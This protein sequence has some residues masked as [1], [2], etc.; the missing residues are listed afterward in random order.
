M[1]WISVSL[2]ELFYSNSELN[3]LTFSKFWTYVNIFAIWNLISPFQI[4]LKK[5]THGVVD[6]ATLIDK[7]VYFRQITFQT[8]WLILD[9]FDL[10]F[11]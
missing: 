9:G 3:S 11:N 6:V 7:I 1:D 5:K 4:K 10:L 8:F 2:N